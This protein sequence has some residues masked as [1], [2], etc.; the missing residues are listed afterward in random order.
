MSL[1]GRVAMVTGGA[2]GIGKATALVLAEK[3]ADIAIN[4]LDLTEAQKTAEEIR[5]KGVKCEA[6]QFDAGDY[7]Q[8]EE[9][10]KKAVEGLGPI[11]I[12]INNAAW[13]TNQD[14]I[15]KLTPDRWDREIRIN[16]C[17]PFYCLKQ[18]FTGMCERK[19]GR[20]VS[21][22]SVA[23]LMGGFGQI[24]YS[25]SKTGLI[26]F[27]KTIA[28]EGAA[29]NITANLVAPG[30]VGTE[31]Y[32]A[33]PEKMRSRIERVHAMRRHG[34]PNDIAYA[35]GY[36]ASEEAKYTTGQVLIVGGGVDLFV[37]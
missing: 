31:S 30:V 33:V 13:T 9:G 35:I 2:K 16:L 29:H 18:V 23:G 20:I 28:L 32:F 6:F 37:F 27:T 21:V 3:G 11:D 25:S 7:V 15:E 22:A 1:E 19:W 5:S 26:G 17:G 8:V 24:G 34:E 14:I 12:L 36:F 4:D 10:F